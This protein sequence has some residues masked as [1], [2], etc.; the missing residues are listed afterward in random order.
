MAGILA[1][2]LGHKDQKHSLEMMAQ[3][4]EKDRISERTGR[5]ALSAQDCWYLDLSFED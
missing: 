5:V 1:T 2:I 4:L 3:V